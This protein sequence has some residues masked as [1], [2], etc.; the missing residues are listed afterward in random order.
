MMNAVNIVEIFSSIQGEGK[1]VGCRQ[2]FVR[3]SGCNLACSYCDTADSRL[4][5]ANAKIEMTP[6]GRD[7]IFNSNPMPIP[8]IVSSINKLL[9]SPHHSVSF[10]GGEPLCQVE[11]L[12]ELAKKVKGQR[13]LETNGTM[14][15][16]LRIVL[17]YV[18]IISM[19]IK[20]PEVSG[21]DYWRE[22]Y[23][24]LKLTLGKDV[25]VKIVVTGQT[26]ESEFIQ[27]M[28]LVADVDSDILVI[29]QPVTPL[30]EVLGISPEKM[31]Q[32]QATALGILR[33]VRVIPQ[34]HKYMGQL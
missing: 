15:E 31:L 9:L 22:H 33:D 29:I 23:E 21:R 26:K 10:T 19:D 13:Y 4:L 30:N 18:D 25:F 24:F 7:F 20:L 8:L 17:P 3:L 32:F 14:P 34:T 1:Y 11:T 16:A 12:A 27:A 5:T 2:L 28:R 6:G